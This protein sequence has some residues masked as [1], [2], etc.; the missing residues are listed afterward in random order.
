MKEQIYELKPDINLTA[1]LRTVDSC[2]G[3]VL[4]ENKGGDRL[5][6]KS[7]LSKYLVLSAATD[8]F[9]LKSSRILCSSRDRS[10]LSEYI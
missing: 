10:L 9:Y 8:P 5:N 1:F 3:E 7:Q 6:L 4:L 2:E